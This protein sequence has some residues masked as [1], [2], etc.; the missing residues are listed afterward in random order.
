MTASIFHMVSKKIRHADQ[1][2][3]R[4]L[5]QVVQ[6]RN[7]VLKKAG[8]KSEVIRQLA[9][10]GW[11]RVEIANFLGIRYQHVRAV[12]LTP[13]TSKGEYIAHNDE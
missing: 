6:S 13:L 7:R 5:A 3:P 9:A 2:N 12:L 11:S 4:Q 10:E 1:S 8:S